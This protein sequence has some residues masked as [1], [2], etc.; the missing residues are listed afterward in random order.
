[1]RKLR[2]TELKLLVQGSSGTRVD[3]LFWF[4]NLL[5]FDYMPCSFSAWLIVFLSSCLLWT[6]ELPQDHEQ[7][8][9]ELPYCSWRNPSPVKVSVKR[10]QPF[11]FVFFY[12]WSLI[13]FFFYVRLFL[14]DFWLWSYG[15]NSPPVLVW[16]EASHVEV[17]S[18]ASPNWLP[19]HHPAALASVP[20]SC[21]LGEDNWQQ[22]SW[23]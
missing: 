16:V 21:L 20:I 12:F 23:G 5:S 22:T 13:A 18:I 9:W 3:T 17:P 10:G 1:M 2:F 6:S 7:H 19:G 11:S 14:P 15:S 4:W 8:P